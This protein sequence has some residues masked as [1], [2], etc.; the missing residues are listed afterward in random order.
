MFRKKKY[1][2]DIKELIQ[3]MIRYQLILINDY[4]YTAKPTFRKMFTIST[5]HMI[6]A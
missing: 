1:S 3:T 6:C 2:L 5:H 4:Y